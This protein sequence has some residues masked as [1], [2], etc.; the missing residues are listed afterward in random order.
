MLH[1]RINSISIDFTNVVKSSRLNTCMQMWEIMFGSSDR[2][3]LCMSWICGTDYKMPMKT[4]YLMRRALVKND[5]YKLGIN[6]VNQENMMR[7]SARRISKLN[8]RFAIG[9]AIM[10]TM[11]KLHGFGVTLYSKC[12]A[13]HASW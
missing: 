10:V 9:F 12:N 8:R 3:G 13:N 2:R 4:K 5:K 1:S 7:H 6:L 11:S